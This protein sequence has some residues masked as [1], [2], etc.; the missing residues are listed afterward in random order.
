MLRTRNKV[1]WDGMGHV[2]TFRSNSVCVCV[3]GW[4]REE[5]GAAGGMILEH[6][7]KSTVL[8]ARNNF[9]KE[10]T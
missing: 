3:C 6:D 4:G 9:C 2:V 10:Q 1:L 8:L 5:Q 7:G